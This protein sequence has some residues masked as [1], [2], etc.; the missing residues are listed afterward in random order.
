MINLEFGFAS[1]DS[2]ICGLFTTNVMLHSY[3]NEWQELQRPKDWV[4]TIWKFQR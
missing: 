3:W 1:V 4:E 2:T